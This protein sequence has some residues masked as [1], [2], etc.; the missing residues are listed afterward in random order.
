MN[1]AAFEKLTRDWT[2]K[3]R[4]SGFRDIEAPGGMISQR[5]PVASRVEDVAGLE[6]A[7]AFL[8]AHEF[9][10]EWD[11]E[12]WEMHTDGVSNRGIQRR[13][14]LGTRKRVDATIARLTAVMNGQ[15]LR[16]RGRPRDPDGFRAEGMK[17]TV[18][19][20]PAHVEALGQMRA[21]FGVGPSEL[22]RRGLLLLGRKTNAVR[23]EMWGHWDHHRRG[24]RDQVD[25]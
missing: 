23:P 14:K 9:A 1:R 11:R 8:H 13:L 3:L 6:A 4:D 19:L 2:A 25:E 15:E 18:R 22:I 12:V 5:Q 17:L 10:S 24:R 21:V 7:R 20:L 16:G